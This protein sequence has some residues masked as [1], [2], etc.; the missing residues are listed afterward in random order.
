V[1]WSRR[2]KL[3]RQIVGACGRLQ[4][5]HAL[6]STIS[7]EAGMPRTNRAFLRPLSRGALHDHPAGVQWPTL[8]SAGRPAT[9]NFVNAVRVQW[10]QRRFE[11]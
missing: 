6:A 7:L 5:L 3:S 1:K 8:W 11:F 10:A 4:T 2:S 9:R